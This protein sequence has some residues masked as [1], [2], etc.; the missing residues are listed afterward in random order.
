MPT[1]QDVQDNDPDDIENVPAG[2]SVHPD[3]LAV[4]GFEA[5]PA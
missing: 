5:I 1:G 4:S 3:A 2:Q